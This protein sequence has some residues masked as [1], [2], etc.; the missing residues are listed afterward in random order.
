MGKLF[1]RIVQKLGG[2]TTVTTTRNKKTGATTRKVTTKQ[3]NW[4]TSYTNSNKPK[5]SRKR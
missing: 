2:S 4:K 5:S 1:E 3:G